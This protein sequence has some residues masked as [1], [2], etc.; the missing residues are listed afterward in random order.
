MSLLGLAGVGREGWRAEPLEQPFIGG[1][2]RTD[3]V[4]PAD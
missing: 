1:K 2:F 4:E 3:F